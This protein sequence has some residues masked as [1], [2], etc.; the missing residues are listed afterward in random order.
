M[1]K[2]VVYD[3]HPKGWKI[4]FLNMESIYC[5]ISKDDLPTNFEDLYVPRQSDCIRLALL[6]KYGG[7]WLDASILL[8]KSLDWVIA[9][10]MNNVGF[11]LEKFS[12]EDKVVES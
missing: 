3:L 5:Y 1:C 11:Y 9:A 8:Y 2:Q 4:N 6:E 10:S 12:I 7:I